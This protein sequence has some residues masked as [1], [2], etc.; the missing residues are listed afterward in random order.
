MTSNK[1]PQFAQLSE[2]AYKEYERAVQTLR[3]E[4]A[5]GRTYDQA[6]SSLTD[7]DQSLKAFVREEFLKTLIAEEH[8]GAGVEISD[9]ALLLE[10]P[11]NKVEAALMT[12]LN[13]MVR[14]ADCHRAGENKTI[15]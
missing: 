10:L 2:N 6:C 3:Q 14:E 7:L 5:R 11:Y 4:L 1:V 8:F 15:N 9:I 13:D 12:L